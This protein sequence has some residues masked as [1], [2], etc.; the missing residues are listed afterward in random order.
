M[1]SL[2]VDV[3]MPGSGKT[4]E[5]RLDGSMLVSE[6]TA[7]IIARIREAEKDAFLIDLAT[8]ILSDIHISARLKPELSLY[9]AGVKSGHRLILL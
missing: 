5:F 1:A 4:Y 2:L 6:A 8:A 3:F 9:A 7:Q